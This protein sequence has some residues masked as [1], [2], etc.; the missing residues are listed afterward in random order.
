MTRAIWI[1]A[2]GEQRRLA[3]LGHPKQMLEVNGEPILRRTL[4]LLREFG[5]P[6][7]L[8]IANA[9]AIP[10][11]ARDAEAR[12]VFYDVL[13]NADEGFVSKPRSNVCWATDPGT[14]ILDGLHLAAQNLI[15]PADSVLV[16]LGD[17][18]WSRAALER[19]VADDRPLFF[20]GTSELSGSIGEV[21]A[22]GWQGGE[23][24]LGHERMRGLLQQAPC[25]RRQDG[26]VL[27]LPQAV[28][29]HLRRLIWWE[30]ECRTGRVAGSLPIGAAWDPAT[31]LP[32]VD[33]TMDIDNDKDVAEIPR[34][35]R[36][37]AAEIC[38]ACFIPDPARDDHRGLEARL[39]PDHQE[40]SR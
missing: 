22:M 3:H 17:V 29:G 39:C 1:M 16:L 8:I 27:R 31:Y 20:A 6:Q 18:V 19:V 11:S 40:A 26:G 25:R 12:G 5:E 34:L 13:E 23:M 30:Y 9:W 33:F 10:E 7:P 2:Q 32:T 37:C 28:G 24:R 38:P 21:Y 14:C 35:S 4:R 15:G 36:L